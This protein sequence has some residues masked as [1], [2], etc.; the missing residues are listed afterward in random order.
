MIPFFFN[1]T[2]CNGYTKKDFGIRHMNTLLQEWRNK[3]PDVP[4]TNQEEE[5]PNDS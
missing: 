2:R 1:R 4:K 5:N 3:F